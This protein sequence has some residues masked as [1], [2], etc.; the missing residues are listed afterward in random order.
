MKVVI[1]GSGSPNEKGH[2]LG[3]W[4][5]NCF[6]NDEVI[7]L[8]RVTGYDFYHNYDEI[9]SIAKTADLFINS[10]CVDNFQSKL[11]RDVYG[12]V[13]YMIVMGSIVGDLHPALNY[14]YS[15]IKAELKEECRLI[16]LRQQNSSTTL[17]HITPTTAESIE[18]G[19]E[20]IRQSDIANIIKFWFDNPAVSNIDCKFFI[21]ADPIRDQEK[22]TK[23][24]KI[25]AYYN[26]P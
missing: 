24:N 7:S 20:G 13:P 23:I 25:L 17:L 22:I 2:V 8:S 6:P 14:D 4:L 12:Y 11:L 10:S 16:P 9:V 15:K 5:L 21:P 18:D 26:V 19:T 3:K 1:T